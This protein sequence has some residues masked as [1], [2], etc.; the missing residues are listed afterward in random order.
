MHNLRE[1]FVTRDNIMAGNRVERDE[2]ITLADRLQ[3]AIQDEMNRILA[4]SSSQRQ[5]E[6]NMTNVSQ[7]A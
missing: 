5:N 1:Q 6:H 4:G 3:L 7:I 2:A